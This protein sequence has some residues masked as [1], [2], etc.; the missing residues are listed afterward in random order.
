MKI[1]IS[2]VAKAF[3]RLSGAPITEAQRL[4]RLEGLTYSKDT[5]GNYLGTTLRDIG[6]TGG[7]IELSYTGDGAPLKVLTTYAAPRQLNKAECQLLLKETGAQWSDGIGEGDFQHAD[8]L[9]IDVDIF[10]SGSKPTVKQTDD[11]IVGKK[12]TTNPLLQLFQ[13]F[14]VDEKAALALVRERV[15][16]DDKDREGKTALELAC[17]KAFADLFDELWQRGALSHVAN[18]SNM[19]SRIAFCSGAAPILEKTVR[20]ARRLVEHGVDVD[21]VDEDGRT[22]LMMA[23]SR[24][25]LPL[26]RYLLSKGANINAQIADGHNRHTVL[27]HAQEAAM[28]QYLLEQGADPSI[29]AANGENAFEMQLRNKH[30]KN[31][32]E[33]AD[34]LKAKLS[35]QRERAEP[36]E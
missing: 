6:V 28:V 12:P 31:Y 16:I 19:L 33:L 13:S 26:V 1:V 11:G 29:C 18:P 22:P 10:P 8:E 4:A 23:A 32:M 35:E 15:A 5:C 21:T 20:I 24:N 7:T 2:G 30:K 17:Y 14:R 27:M 36:D 9:G 34:I 25:N 3:D